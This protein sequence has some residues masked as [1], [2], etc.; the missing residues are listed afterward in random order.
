MQARTRTLLTVWWLAVIACMLVPIAVSWATNVR[1]IAAFT[2]IAWFVTIPLSIITFRRAASDQH[3][4][5]PGW[6]RAALVFQL[7]VSVVGLV[8][9]AHTVFANGAVGLVT[10]ASVQLLVAIL[11]WRAITRPDPRRALAAALISGLIPF[12]AL[13]VDIALD[14]RSKSAGGEKL[15]H[16]LWSAFAVMSTMLAWITAAVVCLAV[17]RT[18][19]EPTNLPGAR[20]VET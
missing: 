7:V 1:G 13:M 16:D 14:T 6:Y 20:A 3:L 17:V 5:R 2:S 15:V 4:Q 19:S 11:T 12:F 18:F 10:I 9:A 8:T